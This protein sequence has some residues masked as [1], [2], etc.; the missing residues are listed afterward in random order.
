MTYATVA[1]FRSYLKQLPTLQSSPNATQQQV[2]ETDALLTDILTRAT[3][4]IDQMLEFSFAAY[5]AASS[6]KV[7][8]QGGRLLALPAHQDASVT[9]VAF[10]GDAITDYTYIRESRRGYLQR[11][12]GWPACVLLDVTAAWG[13]GPAPAS[14]TEMCLELAVNIWR[15]RDRGMFADVIGV[16]ASSGPVGGGG[17][18]YIGTLTKMQQMTL[19]KIKRSCEVT[20]I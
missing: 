8:S 18:A 14:I 6:K 1:Q 5:G 16:D 13:A 17:V 15:S 20:A 10:D 12:N 2:T 9:G 11:V 7:V 19:T 4:A 3:D